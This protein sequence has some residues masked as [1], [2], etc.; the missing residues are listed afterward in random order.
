MV[1]WRSFF[2]CNCQ[3][4]GISKVVWRLQVPAFRVKIAGCVPTRFHHAEK[5][6]KFTT[7]SRKRQAMNI[8]TFVFNPIQENTYVLYDDTGEAAIVDAGNSCAKEDSTIADFISGKGLRLTNV[9]CTHCHW[10]HIFGLDWVRRQYSPR[11]FCHAADLPWI[12]HFSDICN[13]YGFGRR[14][15]PWPTNYYNNGDTL[16]FGNTVL[17]V[18]HTPG[19]SAG[20]VSLYYEADGVLFSGDTLFCSSVGR[21][22]FPGG[23][24]EQL[25]NSISDKLLVLSDDVKILPGHGFSSTIGYERTTNPYLLQL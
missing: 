20:S 25:L 3:I 14:T 24:S 2:L 17:K 7:L 5:N 8:K 16:T 19:H 15:A 22:D 1:V 9:F 13:Q 18:L 23:S 11:I 6:T 4:S 10:D 12:E 21:T